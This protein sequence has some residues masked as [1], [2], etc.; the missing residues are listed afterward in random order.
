MT[1][2]KLFQDLDMSMSSGSENGDD[3]WLTSESTYSSSDGSIMQIQTT[4][5]DSSDVSPVR[6]RDNTKKGKT[7]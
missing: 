4:S 3:L 7:L 1:R 5:G 2:R 6:V